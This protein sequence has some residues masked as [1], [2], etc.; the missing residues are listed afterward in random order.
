MKLAKLLLAIIFLLISLAPAAAQTNYPTVPN[1]RFIDAAGT[2]AWDKPDGAIYF[3]LEYKN[4]Q[5]EWTGNR[6]FI[7]SVCSWQ[8]WFFDPLISWQAR[9]RGLFLKDDGKCDSRSLDRLDYI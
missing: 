7:S 6:Q 5:D 8:I 1:F 9:T 2:L 3:D 4:S